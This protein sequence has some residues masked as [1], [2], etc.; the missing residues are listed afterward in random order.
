MVALLAVIGA[1]AKD[2]ALSQNLKEFVC[3]MI[4]FAI[5][6]YFNAA[7]I[8]TAWHD[9]IAADLDLHK[10]IFDKLN[11]TLDAIGHI[12]NTFI[13]RNY[14]QNKINHREEYLRNYKEN[15]ANFQ[16]LLLKYHQNAKENARDSLNKVYEANGNV[17]S[18][19]SG[20]IVNLF[21]ADNPYAE[22]AALLILILE[23]EVLNIDQLIQ[24]IPYDLTYASN[25]YMTTLAALG[26]LFTDC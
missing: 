9:F 7:D 24:G 14:W 18:Y 23:F 1:Q 22:E 6:M 20:Q 2:S 17:P 16:H 13:V 4:N 10:S 15:P 11:L 5:P 25:L 19:P 8:E 12:A 3:K 26:L 21:A